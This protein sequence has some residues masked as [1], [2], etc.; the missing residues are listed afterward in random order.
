DIVR[1][2]AAMTFWFMFPFFALGPVCGWLADRLSRK[3]L[4][5]AADLIRAL[6]MVEMLWLLRLF[7]SDFA[8]GK[9]LSLGLAVMPLILMGTFAALFSPARL[10]LLPTLI[11]P[12]QLVRA[13]AMTA[14]LGIIASI[15]S[16]VLGGYLVEWDPTALW[17][18]RVDG[19]TFVLSAV[20]IFLIRVPARAETEE[21]HSSFAAI[22]RGFRYVR[23][24][25]RLV[26]LILVSAV[27]WT[28]IGVV[29]SIVP[30]IVKNVFGGSYR[31][32]GIYQGLLIG[33]GLVVGSILLTLMDKA[34]K[35]DLAI[36]WSLKLAG[37]SGALMTFGVWIQN[38]FLCGAALFTIG[39]FGAGIQVSVNSLIQRIVPNYMR[40]RVF[41]VHDLCAVGGLL[42]STGVLGLPDW[43]NIDRH[44]TW[45]M[46]CTSLALVLTGIWTTAIRLRR[47]RFGPAVTFWKNLNDFYC[48]LW[49]RA[50]REGICTIP[51]EG[52]AIVVANHSSTLDP[53]LLV[54]ASPNRVIGYMI[55]VEYAKIPIFSKLVEAIECVPVTRSGQDTA[56][57]KGALRHLQHGKVLGIFPQGRIQN[58]AGPIEVREG[59]GMLALRSGVPVIPA[60]ISG[61]RFSDSIIAPIF[62]RHRAVVRYGPPIDLSAWAGREKDR[63]AYMEV[64]RHIMDKILELKPG[65]K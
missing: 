61:L 27:L 34:L 19:A 33:L 30:A 58:P 28:A 3:W 21:S 44:V 25:R 8:Q 2:Q 64:A 5:F 31:D 62:R 37:L 49:P 65:E 4:M 56:S 59:V 60:H 6:I 9:S 40:G 32:I 45:I 54:S 13:N 18:F 26:E 53:F 46:G 7:D 22:A 48:R 42:L 57:V 52:P 16:A 29:R 39:V 10:S 20:C 11:Q 23:S 51:A 63:A 35:S 12:T 17:N 24:H 41:G 43:P 1:R 47:G 55:A 50:R 15:L 38:Q 14:G 36:S